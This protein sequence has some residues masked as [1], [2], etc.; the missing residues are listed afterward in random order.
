MKQTYTIGV[1]GALILIAGLIAPVSA[2]SLLFFNPSVVES[3]PG[4]EPAIDLIMEGCNAGISGYA[5][6][7]TLDNPT[8][9]SFGEISF[10]SWVSMNKV[11]HINSTTILIQGADLGN[12]V[13]PAL[14]IANLAT[15]NIHALT[16]GYATLSVEPVVIDDDRNGRYEPVSKTASI[17]ISGAGPNPMIPAS[18]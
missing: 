16:A 1:L 9:A 5:L 14:S 18:Q 2:Y 3:N 17:V 7:L 12:Q 4:E 6:Y 11:E 15:V 10:P 8:V 13:E